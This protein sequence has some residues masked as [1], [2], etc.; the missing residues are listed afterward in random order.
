MILKKDD[1]VREIKRLSNLLDAHYN[2]QLNFRNHCYL[3]IA[4]D[5]TIADQWDAQVKKPFT[6]YASTEQLQNALALLNLYL[7]DETKLLADNQNSLLFR[8]RKPKHDAKTE[9]TLF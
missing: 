2:S 3:R 6:K 7:V 1:L 9:I 8:K 5:T 4:Y